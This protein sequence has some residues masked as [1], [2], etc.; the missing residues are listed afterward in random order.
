LSGLYLQPLT[1]YHTT[2]PVGDLFQAFRGPWTKKELAFIG[3]GTGTMLAYGVPGQ[4]IS[5]F[6]I[7][8]AVVR[9]AENPKYFTFASQCQADTW[10]DGRHYRLVMGDARLSMEQ[11][12]D[13]RFG[14]ILVDAFSS[15]AIPIH[16]ITR[17]AIEL[18]VR[19]LAPH[20]IIAL[21]IS[22]RY[23]DLEPVTAVL[24]TDLKLAARTRSDHVQRGSQ[25]DLQ[26]KSSSTWVLLARN[27]RDLF[28]LTENP[29]W[30]EHPLQHLVEAVEQARKVPPAEWETF[31]DSK[32]DQIS[33]LL[34]DKDSDKR[35]KTKEDV[36]AL[37]DQA[38]AVTDE[39]FESERRQLEKTARTI[40][41]GPLWTDDFSNIWRIFQW[42]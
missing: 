19:K 33:R 9:I 37:L 31:R 21:H 40:A 34:T 20:G 22:N 26:G 4:K 28:P 8:P 36:T 1:Y 25:L 11:E 27:E 3:L 13:G 15:D 32:A 35:R 42:N 5:V 16:L 7:N 14:I 6:E 12:P 29:E 41:G 39:E 17:E 24:S 38:R 10:P 18:Y 2:G 30:T 23:L